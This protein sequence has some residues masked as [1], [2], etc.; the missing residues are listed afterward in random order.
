[1]TLNALTQHDQAPTPATVSVEAQAEKEL[2][3][4]F[5]GE[6]PPPE[7][8]PTPVTPPVTEPQPAPQAPAVVQP[9]LESGAPTPSVQVG[10]PSVSP[11]LAVP[12]DPVETKVKE[13]FGTDPKRAA[14]AILATN[15]RAA[16]MASKLKELGLDPKTLLPVVSTAPPAQAPPAPPVVVDPKAVDAEI[17]HRLDNDPA[18]VSLVQAWITSDSHLKELSS[19]KASLASEVAKI[20]M[21][22]SIPEIQADEFKRDQYASQLSQ[23]EQALLRLQLDESITEAKQERLNAAASRFTEK[24]RSEVA[25]DFRSEATQRQNEAELAQYQQD[26]Y[27]QYSTSWPL[28]VEKAIADV[29]IPVELVEDFKEDAKVAALAHLQNTEA[30]IDDV[31]AFVGAR[32]KVMMDRM[33]RFHRMQSATYGAQAAARTAVATASTPSSIPSPTVLNPTPATG[34]PQLA[35]AAFE[36][37]LENEANLI[38]RQMGLW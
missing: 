38:A 6:L 11:P 3:A 23:K 18:F 20:N 10:Q 34:R 25:Q 32:A 29:K 14:E 15:N 30:P 24:Y 4:F 17:T 8:P 2:G 26:L 35:D 22:L 37:A 33:D 31:Y 5:R 9:P 16:A 21:A 12:E 1:M 7:A 28:A 27:A 13:I 19:Q 36:R